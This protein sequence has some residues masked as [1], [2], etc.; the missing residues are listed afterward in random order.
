MGNPAHKSGVPIR[1]SSGGKLDRRFG[2]KP[3][4]TWSPKRRNLPINKR[5]HISAVSTKSDAQ[6]GYDSSSEKRETRHGISCPLA[7]PHCRC[8]ASLYGG[9]TQILFGRGSI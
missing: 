4:W 2:A 7:D 9:G 6:D 3:T 8:L 1:W 5:F